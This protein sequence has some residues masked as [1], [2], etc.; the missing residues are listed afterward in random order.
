MPQ[1]QETEYAAASEVMAISTS[2]DTIALTSS[3]YSWTNYTTSIQGG[4]G[5]GGPGGPG[6]GPGGLMDGM[7]SSGDFTMKNRIC[8]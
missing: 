4:G 1:Q 2:Y 3:S 8:R 5:F 7:F 6:G